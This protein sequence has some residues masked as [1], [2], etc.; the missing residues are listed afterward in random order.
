MKGEVSDF[1]HKWFYFNISVSKLLIAGLNLNSPK[2]VPQF[3][4]YNIQIASFGD[5]IHCVSHLLSPILSFWTLKK[6]SKAL[7]QNS[8]LINLGGI[9]K[10]KEIFFVSRCFT[11]GGGPRQDRR[12]ERK[13]LNRSVRLRLKGTSLG[14]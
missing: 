4:T 5:K 10:G 11:G 9:V 6:F 14:S 7:E 2:V 12:E 3:Q 1:I 8:W 13:L